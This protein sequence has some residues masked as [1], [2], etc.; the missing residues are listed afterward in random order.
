M[1]ATDDRAGAGWMA[2]VF[3]GKGRRCL[4][5]AGG[6]FE[7]VVKLTH[8]CNLQCT[9]CY[10]RATR[11][12]ERRQNGAVMP[13]DTV[14]K[15]ARDLLKMPLRSV[16]LTFHGGEPLISFSHLR[17]AVLAAKETA[18]DGANLKL[19]VQT[20]GTLVTPEIAEF[21]AS[22]GVAVGISVDG[23]CDNHNRYR[24][25][26]GAGWMERIGV[27]IRMLISYGIVPGVL[28]VAS[29]ANIAEMDSIVR[30]LHESGVRSV[31]VNPVRDWGRSI[32]HW[33]DIT[34][35]N[36]ELLEMYQR[37]GGCT[38]EINSRVLPSAR[39]V[40]RTLESIASVVAF[41]FPSD[42]CGEPCLAGR[43]T[44][45]FEPEGEVYI[46]DCA[47]K[48]QEYLLGNIVNDR[49]EDL[50][51]AASPNVARLQSR[52]C[53]DID[54]CKDCQWRYM[55]FAGCGI[56]AEV[57]YG[58]LC[59]AAPLCSVYKGLFH[60]V[61]RMFAGHKLQYLLSRPERVL[62]AEAVICPEGGRSIVC[63][64]AAQ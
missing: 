25:P 8:G 15:I 30:W 62:G 37:V 16:I 40:E 7:A 18:D 50:I 56:D 3:L 49:L 46:C 55:C 9:Y 19:C 36:D 61:L 13:V 14:R 22:N 39:T 27:A 38:T 32:L 53:A 52:R 45:S 6:V 12:E 43:L 60:Y 44:A 4:T 42:C 57:T 58:R 23:Y 5:P 24:W 41:G 35:S 64:P 28:V 47:P 51:G 1:C 34:V 20:N 26:A 21:L 31:R 11:G 54:R 63:P 10:D 33:R 29:R 17:E 59:E 2:S 48:T